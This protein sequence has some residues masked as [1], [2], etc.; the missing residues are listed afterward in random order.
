[1]E[2]KEGVFREGNS[3]LNV[4]VIMMALALALVIP[5]PA[6]C[7]K[8]GQQSHFGSEG[9]DHSLRIRKSLHINA[10]EIP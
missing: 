1:L 9:D 6:P 2:R 5:T 7:G 3:L 10:Q 4:G 8:E